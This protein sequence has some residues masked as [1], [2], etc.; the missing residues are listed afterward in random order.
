MALIERTAI[1]HTA[2]TSGYVSLLLCLLDD[3]KLLKVCFSSSRT[4][5]YVSAV[6][7]VLKCAGA[8]RWEDLTGKLLRV[9]FKSASGRGAVRA[10][11]IGHATEN[12]WFRSS[13]HRSLALDFNS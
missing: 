4:C 5:N 6:E 9:E 10:V 1:T 2:L 11:A 8:C 3:P 7:Q 12:I 13:Y